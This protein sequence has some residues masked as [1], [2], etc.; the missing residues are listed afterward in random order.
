M[1]ANDAVKM[2]GGVVVGFLLT[3]IGKSS[4][5]A[6]DLAVRVAVLAEKVDGLI[7]WQG[8]VDRNEKTQWSEIDKVKKGVNGNA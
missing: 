5:S 8:V 4:D 2:F 3:R 7:R 1:D 6:Q